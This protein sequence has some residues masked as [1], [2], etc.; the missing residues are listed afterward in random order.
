MYLQ[1]ISKQNY[2]R[3][4][5]SCLFTFILHEGISS[6]FKKKWQDSKLEGCLLHCPGWGRNP[7][8]DTL[9]SSFADLEIGSN[10]WRHRQALRL[11]H[12]RA[13][14]MVGRKQIAKVMWRKPPEDSVILAAIWKFNIATGNKPEILA[15]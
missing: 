9:S 3:S 14:E 5:N 13:T 11:H 12:G 7:R 15:C 1:H 6:I 4:Y 2:N 10:Q 8:V